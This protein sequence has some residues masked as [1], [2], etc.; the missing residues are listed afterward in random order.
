MRGITV[1]H[2]AAIVFAAG[3]S[4]TACGGPHLTTL[5]GTFTDAEPTAG[6]AVP[7]T[8]AEWENQDNLGGNNSAW[9]AVIKDDSVPAGGA[10]IRWTGKPRAELLLGGWGVTCTGTWSMTVPDARVSYTVSLNGA[11]GSTV[12]PASKAGN[13]ISLNLSGSPFA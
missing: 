9:E 10:V 4:L 13:L 3:L 12:I 1:I 6:M 7:A 11:P 8:C 5:R 2:A